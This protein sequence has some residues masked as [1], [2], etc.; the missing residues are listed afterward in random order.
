MVSTP[1]FRLHAVSEDYPGLHFTMPLVSAHDGELRCVGSSF[2]VFPGLAVT[3]AHVVRDWVDYQETRDGYRRAG[4]NFSVTAYQYFQ[5]DFL[6]WVVDAIEVL[7]P[8]DIAFLRFAK[9]NWWGTESGQLVT[10]S[11]RLNFNPPVP[12]E[13]V[14]V[15]GFPNSSVLDGVVDIKPS[16]SLARVREVTIKTPFSFRP[17]SYVELEGEIIGGMSGG[18]C[19]DG[20]WNV[21]GMC[22]KGW[23][24]IEDVPD[25][26]PLSF[27]ALLW[28]AMSLE[29]DLFKTGRFPA[30]DLFQKGPAQAVGARRVQVTSHGES[31]IGAVDPDEL[32]PLIF[33]EPAEHLEGALNFAAENA[34]L[35]LTE[36]KRAISGDESVS[37]N[38]L[39]RH[40]RMF[41]WELNSALQLSL[42]LT[43]V[44]AGFTLPWV[45]E[46]EEFVQSW[47][48]QGAAPATID[49]LNSLG[50]SWN[51]IKLFEVRT[52]SMKATTG[53]LYLQ[54]AK[55]DKRFIAC[56]LDPARE[57]G[58]QIL[59]PSGLQN[60]YDAARRF[61]QRLLRLAWQRGSSRDST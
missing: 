10:R 3:A 39:H 34:T 2:L 58:Q 29:I 53:L 51:S 12:G 52:Y 18:P 9:P 48:D 26:S 5:G 55:L 49:A 25:S 37:S 11:A 50:F 27:M 15:F 60:Y 40:I 13:T 46:W 33:Q 56:M 28:P 42:R 20:N 57:G 31:Q 36:I 43:A 17:T 8:A 1:Q 19:F 30:L 61:S 44:R 24:F 35:A 59:V 45:F 21:I 4:T 14:R 54:C 41:F 22:S 23:N 32:K 47:R 16:E 38:I 7:W 6:P